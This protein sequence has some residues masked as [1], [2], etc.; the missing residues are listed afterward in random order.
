MNK[1]CPM[2]KK[3]LIAPLVSLFLFATQGFTGE[4]AHKP[5][6]DIYQIKKIPDMAGIVTT[7]H[8]VRVYYTYQGT[9]LTPPAVPCLPL[10]WN[11][12]V[13]DIENET[14]AQL[15]PHLTHPILFDPQN[16]NQGAKAHVAYAVFSSNGKRFSE[17]Y[18]GYEK[19]NAR[20]MS[21]SVIYGMLRK[22]AVA[23]I[24]NAIRTSPEFLT[25]VE[26]LQ[27][28]DTA[29]K[30]QAESSLSEY[31]RGAGWNQKDIDLFCIY[32]GLDIAR[33]DI[34]PLDRSAFCDDSG[35]EYADIA[36]ANLGI[37]A[38]LG[39]IRATQYLIHL[40][41][42]FDPEFEKRIGKFYA[43]WLGETAGQS[44]GLIH[45]FPWPQKGI[46]P[47]FPIG[48]KPGELRPREAALNEADAAQ[49]PKDIMRSD[50]I[51]N[52]LSR[53]IDPAAK[54]TE[55]EKAVLQN[56]IDSMGDDQPLPPLGLLR[57]N[58]SVPAKTKIQYV[59][60]YRQFARLDT[61]APS[62]YQYIV[63]FPQTDDTAN[64]EVPS[65]LLVR[66]PASV[67]FSMSAPFVVESRRG[68]P[69]ERW[70]KEHDYLTWIDYY[71]R[72]QHP[73]VG[74]L[75]LP[76]DF[77]I[78]YLAKTD[79]GLPKAVH[80]AIDLEAWNAVMART[81]ASFERGIRERK[82]IDAK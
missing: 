59:I 77:K 49:F 58:I 64:R 45:K 12:T 27:K 47:D 10:I 3:N 31:L 40:A 13:A 34:T 51:L 22:E 6:P 56:I 26:S 30:I 48:P 15:S 50:P 82:D 52:Y 75:L 17:E 29:A 67:P 37:L 4:Q 69:E 9:P 36:N 18:N 70:S 1:F 80:I 33:N 14:D 57:F 66:A 76:H 21:Y 61:H 54:L 7:A 19:I 74:D 71:H 55:P 81:K 20:L 62:T 24:I 44:V 65:C 53:K 68:T 25:M 16:A 39:E 23:I 73:V 8:A 43:S 2:A 38:A 11:A 63:L 78:D 5:A 35:K 42:K 60:T 41:A 32:S 79:K 46:M 72:Y 28:A